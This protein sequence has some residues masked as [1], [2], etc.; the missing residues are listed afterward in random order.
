MDNAGVY[1][2]TASNDVGEET[3]TLEV[4]MDRECEEIWGGGLFHPLQ[5]FSSGHVTAPLRLPHRPCTRLV[6]HR[7]TAALLTFGFVLFFSRSAL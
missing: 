5:S 3:C 7:L 1:R 4:P 2:C 6:T